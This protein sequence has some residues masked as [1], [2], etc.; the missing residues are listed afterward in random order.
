MAGSVQFYGKENTIEA[1]ESRNVDA[2]SVFQHK[3]LLHKGIGATDFAEFVT[4]LSRGSSNA[5]YTVCV[6]EDITDVKKIKNTTPNDGGFN[7]RL[8]DESQMIT[9]S[10]YSRMGSMQQLVDEV[11]ALRLEV[12]ELQEDDEEEEKPHNLGMMGDILAHPAIAPIVPNLVQSLVSNLMGVPIQPMPQH[13]YDRV[14]SL[15]AITPDEENKIQ[16][17]LKKLKAADP[18]IGTHLLQ[19]ADIAEKDRNSFNVLLTTLES[20]NR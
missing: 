2:W 18:K 5:I 12:Q 8:N 20:L 9:N 16:Q 11:K 7:F 14:S 15:G 4:M 10:Q 6:Y 3:Q 19:L 13:N 17:A 1:F